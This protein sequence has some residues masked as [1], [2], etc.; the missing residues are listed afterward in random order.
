MKQ[1]ADW[2]HF[3]RCFELPSGSV[4]IETS[5]AADDAKEQFNVILIDFISHQERSLS[6]SQPVD[7][8]ENA[9]HT[10][11]RNNEA[12]FPIGLE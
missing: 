7:V 10:E 4:V 3:V 11:S 1:F 5:F 6:A 12:S 9:N 8:N 2:Q